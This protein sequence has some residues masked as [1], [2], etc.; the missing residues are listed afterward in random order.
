METI[1]DSLF[2]YLKDTYIFQSTRNIKNNKTRITITDENNSPNEF[3]LLRENIDLNLNKYDIKYLTSDDYIRLENDLYILSTAFCVVKSFK[4]NFMENNI[5]LNFLELYKDTNPYIYNYIKFNKISEINFKLYSNISF[6][7]YEN[8]NNICSRRMVYYDE[9]KDKF[10]SLILDR[11][12]I[13]DECVNIYS[14]NNYTM[15]YILIYAFLYKIFN[16][17][18]FEEDFFIP[19]ELLIYNRNYKELEYDLKYVKNKPLMMSVF[20][21]QE[22]DTLYLVLPSLINRGIIIDPL[23]IKNKDIFI[24]LGLNSKY[25]TTTI[26]IVN[27]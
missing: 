17:I 5:F 26:D 13:L 4:Y 7:H 21:K 16:N 8:M 23:F 15:V 22:L 14:K 2:K 11:R 27:K 10:D 12:K 9:C 3:T 25:F 20:S 1:S 19:F 6:G 18:D 24:N